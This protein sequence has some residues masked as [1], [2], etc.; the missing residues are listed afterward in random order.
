MVFEVRVF[1]GA[2]GMIP[3]GLSSLTSGS[4]CLV[5]FSDSLTSCF[6][7]PPGTTDTAGGGVA[8]TKGVFS[9]FICGYQPENNY[10]RNPSWGKVPIQALLR[11]IA[12]VI[13]ASLQAGC[14]EEFRDQ[15]FYRE[16]CGGF[17]PSSPLGA[18]FQQRT[19]NI[20]F[21]AH[22]PLFP[23]IFSLFVII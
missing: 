2:D 12:A 18:I 5:S 6:R 23:C 4:F 1:G 10:N 14:R 17:T 3:T 21:N 19:E 13:V 9:S 16:V 7:N 15:E 11:L 20:P 8:V 22:D